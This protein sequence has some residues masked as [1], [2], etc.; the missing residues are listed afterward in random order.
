MKTSL[1]L[2]GPDET[3]DT[4]YQGRILVL[5][6]KKGYRFSVDSPL[7][8]AFVQTKPGEELLELGTGNAIISLL[9]SLKPFNRI[10]ALEIQDPLADLARRNVRLNNLGSRILIVQADLRSFDPGRKFDVIFSNPPYIK[11]RGGQLSRSEEKSI[12]KHELKCD[13]SDIMRKARELLKENGRAYFIYPAKRESDFKAAMENNLLRLKTLRHV[14]PRENG[15]PNFFLAE[16]RFS[17]PGIEVRS[18][19]IL[20]NRDGTYTEE[21][22]KIFAGGSIV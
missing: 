19:F 4:F 10:T 22:Q 7:L 18:P 1:E 16:C 9:L 3:L 14:L 12:A 20:Y 15:L 8:A 5:Q 6:K 21:A 17:S 13:I 11:W 2:K